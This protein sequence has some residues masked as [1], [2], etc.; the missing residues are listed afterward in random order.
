MVGRSVSQKLNASVILSLTKGYTDIHAGYTASL[1]TL[2]KQVQ[3]ATL[4]DIQSRGLM[5]I[6]NLLF[7][8][9]QNVLYPIN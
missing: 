6:I 9:F 1:Y 5:V 2:Y 4:Q 7:I 8:S 3:H